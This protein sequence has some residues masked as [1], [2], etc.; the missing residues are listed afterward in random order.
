MVIAK[1][2]EK[3]IRAWVGK[4]RYSYK[5]NKFTGFFFLTYI[6]FLHI[7]GIGRLFHWGLMVGPSQSW[8]KEMFIVTP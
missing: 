6:Y 4:G 7:Y 1:G 8:L 5:E 3:N 2:R